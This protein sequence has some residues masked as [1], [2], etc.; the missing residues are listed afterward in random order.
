MGH[1]QFRRRVSQ[2]LREGKI[3]KAIS[4]E[5]LQEHQIGVACILDLVRQELLHLAGVSLL[6][7][8]M[9]PAKILPRLQLPSD[10]WFA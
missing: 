9:H 4:L 7:A 10:Y 8:S 2:P 5:H 6:K 1:H 3:L